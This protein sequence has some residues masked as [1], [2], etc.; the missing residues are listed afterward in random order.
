MKRKLDVIKLSQ[1]RIL[2]TLW[3]KRCNH[4]DKLKKPSQLEIWKELLKY[5]DFEYPEF[6]QFV[7]LMI[8]TWPNTDFERAYSR[9]EM[10]TTKCRNQLKI[11]DLETLFVLAYLLIPLKPLPIQKWSCLYRRKLLASDC[12]FDFNSF[13]T[14]CCLSAATFIDY[15][16]ILIPSQLSV[17]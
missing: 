17:A 8:A 6:C 3:L 11:D 10:F 9:L 14:F 1:W 15:I 13:L 4:T 2:N 16:S 12:Y 7:Q 5:H